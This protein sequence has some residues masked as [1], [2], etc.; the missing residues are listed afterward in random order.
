MKKFKKGQVVKSY[1][2]FAGEENSTYQGFDKKSR[3]HLLLNQMGELY[4]FDEN[5][6]NEKLGRFECIIA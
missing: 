6:Y 1:I 5:S 2:Q 4:G 3:K